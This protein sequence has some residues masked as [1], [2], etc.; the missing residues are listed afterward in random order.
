MFIGRDAELRELKEKLLNDRFEAILVYGRRRIGKTELI[1]EAMKDFAGTSI[2]YE[3]KNALI[4]DNLDSFTSL[5]KETFHIPLHF[6]SFKE[7]LSY[8]FEYSFDH[9][10]LLVLDEF[11]FLSKNDPLIIS[12]IRDLI[13][14]HHSKCQ[15]KLILSGSLIE[16]MKSLND[17]ASETYGRFTGII[18]LKPFGYYESSL[19]YPSYSPEEKILMYSC[20]GGVAFFSSLID[21]RKGAVENIIDLILRPHAILQFEVENVIGGEVSK[22]PMVSSLFSALARG[23]GKYSD[24]LAIS[25]AKNSPD[26]ALKKLLDLEIVK[27][28]APIND[29]NNKKKTFYRFSDNLVEFYYRYI[30]RHK[31]SNAILNPEDFY[32]KF[33]KED[34]EKSYLPKKFEEIAGE[35]LLRK[36]NAHELKPLIYEIGTYFHDDP[37]KRRNSQ[38]DLVTYD[39]KGYIAY[40]C[41][42]SEHPIGISVLRE[43]EEQ[44][45]ISGLDVYKLG[46]ISKK[47]FT[48]EVDRSK[49]NLFSLDEFYG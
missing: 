12:D 40:E 19:F 41:K 38:F 9:K 45:A 17:G 8:L 28:V 36:S 3:S 24:L 2:Y 15:M 35:F 18:D 43:E 6:S 11:P 34:L 30:Y 4:G 44:I 20:F 31:S 32:E 26:Y 22:I 21:P 13:D 27:K 47:G 46:F 16:A 49:Y 37:K 42:Y 29:K 33:V 5:L 48:K 23:V 14:R 25:G 1:K 7:A 10:T 39:E